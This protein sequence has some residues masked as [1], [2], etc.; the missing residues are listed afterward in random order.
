MDEFLVV[1]AFK[2][3]AQRHDGE[4]VGALRVRKV[5]AH[6]IRFFIPSLRAAATSP[7]DKK[8]ASARLR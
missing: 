3:V 7:L 6:M 8:L 5:G 1:D 2:R 4:G